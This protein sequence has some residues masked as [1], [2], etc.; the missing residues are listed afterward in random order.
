[1]YQLAAAAMKVNA[2]TGARTATRA[3]PSLR[4]NARP[5]AGAPRMFDLP[6]GARTGVTKDKAEHWLYVVAGSGTVQR[7]G[8]PIALKRGTLV[9]IQRNER[10]EI[11]N[12]GSEALR[13]ISMNSTFV[14]GSPSRRWFEGSSA[15]LAATAGVASLVISLL[16]RLVG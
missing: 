12:D 2:T 16:V 5:S 10:H 8:A 3:S 15:T 11:V 6:P 7:N 13:A 9:V 14:E 1:M 4:S